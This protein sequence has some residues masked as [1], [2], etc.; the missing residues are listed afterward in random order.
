MCLEQRERGGEREE[1]RAGKGQDRLCM[2]LWAAGRTGVLILGHLW[3]VFFF[4]E[5]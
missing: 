4:F 2:A 3:R 1:G 5:V